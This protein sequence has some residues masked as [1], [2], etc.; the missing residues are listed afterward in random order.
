MT[1]LPAALHQALVSAK[2]TEQDATAWTAKLHRDGYDHVYALRHVVLTCR[3]VEAVTAECRHF[4]LLKK[5][6]VNN[7]S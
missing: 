5:A 1:G 7:P 6:Q 3:T 2:L 4:A